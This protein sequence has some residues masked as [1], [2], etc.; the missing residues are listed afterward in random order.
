[1]NRAMQVCVCMC[2]WVCVWMNVE[3]CAGGVWL[4]CV[5]VCGLSVGMCG[6]VYVAGGVCG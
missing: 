1:M 4:V 5:Y 3:M 6:Y 2:A